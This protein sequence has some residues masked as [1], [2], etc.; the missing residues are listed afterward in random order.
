[1][2]CEICDTNINMIYAKKTKSYDL[3]EKCTDEIAKARVEEYL[4]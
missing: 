4:D 3:C 2:R 1:L